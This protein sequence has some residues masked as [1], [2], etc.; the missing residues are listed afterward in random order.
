[1]FSAPRPDY[2]PFWLC[3]T[4][5]LAG[6]GLHGAGGGGGR[7]EAGADEGR[8][9]CSQFHDG[10]P[11]LQEGS[12]KYQQYLNIYYDQTYQTC[13]D[14]MLVSMYTEENMRTK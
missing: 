6:G 7:Q 14:S 11:H 12:E 5:A 9:T 2:L 4:V 10:L 8:E 13:K 1:M 3:L